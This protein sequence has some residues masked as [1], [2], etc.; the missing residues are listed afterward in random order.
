M[1]RLLITPNHHTKPPVNITT[2]STKAE[3]LSNACE[4]MDS[5]QQQI[6]ALKQQQT[7]LLILSG[8]L[9]LLLILS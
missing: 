7:V 4:A 9:T 1:A 6:E 2:A 8:I 5:Q 3:I